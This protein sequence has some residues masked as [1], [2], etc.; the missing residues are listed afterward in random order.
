MSSL[1]KNNAVARHY[2]LN[3]YEVANETGQLES[4]RA[5]LVAL[6]QCLQNDAS[7]ANLLS[8]KIF[9]HNDLSAI[10]A[11]LVKQSGFC[12]VVNNLMQILVDNNRLYLFDEIIKAFVKLDSEKKGEIAVQ[13]SAAHDLSD[14]QK[15]NVKK[16][17]EAA[18]NSKVLMNLEIDASLIAGIKIKYGSLEM[19]ASA[20]GRLNAMRQSLTSVIE[21]AVVS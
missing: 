6:Q 20:Y 8:S 5:E 4:V 18:F 3:I 2:A 12:S 17:L 13:V 9:S 14:A 1:I 15:Q 16:A 11:G 21:R 19:D 7:F 10:I